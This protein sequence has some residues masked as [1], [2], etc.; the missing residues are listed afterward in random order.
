GR[1]RVR[2]WFR[3]SPEVSSR[4]TM[5]RSRW[6]ST[7]CPA[8]P[9]PRTRTDPFS[10]SGV[11]GDHRDDP[12]RPR[13]PRRLLLAPAPPE[14]PRGILRVR[15]VRRQALDRRHRHLLTRPPRVLRGGLVVV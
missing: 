11:D 6:W 15:P 1:W 14:P 3:R 2:S 10:A 4:W 5:T 9:R 8:L 13:R 12:G 7:R